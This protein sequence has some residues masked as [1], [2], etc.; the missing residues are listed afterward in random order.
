MAERQIPLSV[1]HFDCYWMREFQ[2]CDV[3]WDSRTFPDVRGMLRRFR[4]RGLRV[5]VWLNPYVAQ[6]TPFFR[7]GVEGG[8]FLRRADG[9]GIKQLDSW[10]P[11]MA[12]IDFTNPDAC[13]WFAAK[14]ETLLE[15]GVDAFKTDFGERIPLDVVYHNGAD[16]QSMHNYYSYLYTRCVFELL[17]RVK[18]R[19]HAVVFARSATVGSQQ[20][21]VHWG[22]D[23]TASYAS[24]AETLR[25]G[26][27]LAMSGFAFWSHDI[28]GFEQTATAD[29]YK[30]W[31]AFGMLSSHSRLH[32]STSY[33]VPWLFDDESSDVVRHFVRLK[34]RLM[35]YIFRVSMEAR[36][37]GAPVMRPMVFEF[38]I[39]PATAHIDM[40]YMLGGS[41]LVAPVFAEDGRV[42]YYLPEGAWTDYFTGRV[43]T[44]GRWY[45]DVYDYLSLPL[46]VRPGTLLALGAEESRPDYDYLKGVELRLYEL[47][48]EQSTTCEV[49]TIAGEV[50]L[51]VTVERRKGVLTVRLSRQVSEGA[52][53]LVGIGSVSHVRGGVAQRR[54]A[55]TVIV[56][57]DPTVVVKL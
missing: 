8:Y 35:P 24:M 39:D 12:L 28:S 18:G 42:D 43:R 49:P 40:Q 41:L 26:L 52:L 14:L 2:W 10:Q 4:E 9:H 27:S 55:D 20:F 23:S 45:S 17:E 44:G 57:A 11:G 30:R 16:P 38:P 3:E 6:G 51:R 37:T 7:E 34:H 33:R 19:G 25:G 32:G 53:V 50:A 31:V 22:G 29:L 5:T 13:R 47:G 15:M 54:G 36:D 21:P 46:Y 48:E 1:F 56:P